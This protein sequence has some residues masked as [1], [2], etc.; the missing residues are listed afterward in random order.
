MTRYT[1][2]FYVRNV[3]PGIWLIAEPMHV[4][5]W[6]LEGNERA[7][8]LDTGMGISKVRPVVERLTN[9]P[10]TVLNTHYHFD[11]TGGNHEFDDIWIHELGAD[12]LNLEW[13]VELTDGVLRVID[14]R[15]AIAD[16][17]RQL[18]YPYFWLLGAESEPRPLPVS[19][20]RRSYR[21]IPSRA[22]RTLSDGERIDLGG[23]KLTV[24]HTPG[25]S[26]DSIC[27]WLEDEGVLFGTD[28]LNSGPIYCQFADSD[29]EALGA[30]VRRL[31]ELRPK[32]RLMF[33][34]HYGRPCAEPDLL[35][36]IADGVQQ[37]IRGD[38]PLI[39]ARDIVDLPILEARF[40]HFQVTLPDPE[41]PAPA[42]R[43]EGG[44]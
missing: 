6:L 40:D 4:N 34:H 44:R 31:E 18:D 21:I 23:R 32:V 10:V 5:L 15:L 28:T 41:R 12:N 30:S 2:W 16:L 8:L 7:L 37:V 13:P 1:D 3:H 9:L 11:H 20:D 25:H 43:L 39:P 26:P 35:T 22:T 27:L 14:R 38:W 33:F 29:L 19:F 17:Y 36:E 24:M 42:F